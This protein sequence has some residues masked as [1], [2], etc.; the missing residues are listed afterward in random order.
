MTISKK[1]YLSSHT[2]EELIY[3]P[4]ENIIGPRVLA[5]SE[6]LIFSGPPS[7]GKTD[8]LLNWMIH[9]ASGTSFMGM[10]PQRP[11]NILYLQ[12]EGYFY[13]LRDD[14]QKIMLDNQ[15]LIHAKN[16]IAFAMPFDIQLKYDDEFNDIVEASRRHFKIGEVDIIVID[17]WSYSNMSTTPKLKEE[18]ALFLEHGLEK[19]RN[20]INPKAGIILAHNFCGLKD[21]WHEHPFCNFSNIVM[22]RT[23]W[24]ESTKQLVF[25]LNNKT[26]ISKK[27]MAKIDGHWYELSSSSVNSNYLSNSME[28]YHD[29]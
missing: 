16:N 22:D 28:E 2:A 24:K 11:L 29:K 17:S 20:I 18:M 19:L 23:N 14:L 10:Y 27:R 13:H 25:R 26:T 6:T 9:L 8:F 5:P 12:S 4:P 7:V 15:N 3:S 1:T 21:I